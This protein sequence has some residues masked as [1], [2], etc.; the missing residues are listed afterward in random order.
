MIHHGVIFL[1]S[2]KGSFKYVV[3]APQRLIKKNLFPL[4]VSRLAIS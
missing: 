3:K 2:A 1:K 4:I